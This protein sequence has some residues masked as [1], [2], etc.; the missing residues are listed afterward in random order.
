MREEI[1]DAAEQIVQEKGLEALSFQQ[2]ATAV[3]LSKASVFHHFRNSNA[4]ATALIER[5]SSKYGAEYKEIGMKQKTAPKKL[6][7]IVKS[8]DKGLKDN[9]LC[10][11]AALGSSYANLSDE[12]QSSL[13]KSSNAA[14][15]V[16]TDVFE[17]GRVEGTLDF[18]GNPRSAA[19]TFLASLQGMQQLA[20]YSGD[21]E[22][23]MKSM[24]HYL[25]NIEA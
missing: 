3:G 12:L 21:L 19:R 15:D 13:M 11:L 2:L 25:K 16:F 9:R 1:L 6:R 23:F 10:L 5:C 18:E 17:Q 7:K 8:F 24:D 20:R 22:V 4:L 14:I